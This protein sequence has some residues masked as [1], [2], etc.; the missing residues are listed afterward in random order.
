MMIISQASAVAQNMVGM[1]A[2]AASTAVSVLAACNAIG[3]ILAGSLSDKI[4]R[5]NTLMASCIVSVIG[6][7]FLY[8]TKVSMYLT[9]Y[10]GIS[11]VGLCFGAFMGVFPGFTADQFGVKNNSVNYGIMFIGFAAAGFFGPTIMRNVYVRS[12]VY[13]PAFLIA[14]CLN[15]AGIVLT[16]VYRFMNGKN[17]VASK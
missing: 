10:I 13:Q 12:G 9:F 15:L 6:L 4:G 14:C 8:V 2:M 7:M 1:T 11:L 16:V 3:R 5:I 17:T